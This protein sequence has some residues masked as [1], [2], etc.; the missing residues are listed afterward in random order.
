MPSSDFFNGLYIVPILA[1]LILIHEIGHFVSARMCG[2][3]VEEFGIGIPP[4]LFGVMRKGVLWSVNAIPFGGFVRVKGEDGKNVE[5]DSMN[6]KRPSQR[7]FFLAAGAGMNILLAIALMILV[8]GIEGIPHQSIYIDGV[9]S[10]SP[11]AKAG[12]QRGDRIVAVNGK[13]L[14]TADEVRT[15]A[16]ANAGREMT[17]TIERRGKLIDTTVS[18]RKNPPEGEGR[19]GVLITERSVGNL[20]IVE[21]VPDSPAAIAGLQVGDKIASINNRPVTDN[22]VLAT[23]L[24]R[25]IGSSVPL[26][27]ERNGQQVTTTIGVPTRRANEELT[28]TAGFATLKLVPIFEHVPALKVVPRGFEEA[29][30]TTKMMTIGLKELFS[31]RQ[32]LEQIAGPVGMGQLTSELVDESELPLWVTLANIAIVLSLNLALLNLLPIPALDGARLMFVLIE[33]LRGGRKIAP[34]KEGLVHLAGMVVLIGLMFVIA[35][36]DVRRIVSGESFL[37]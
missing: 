4:R 3:K 24:E 29:Y 16:A 21:L 17:T 12:W 5:P 35:F 9:S 14:E 18:P 2:V 30:N 36:S 26:V 33:V 11:A 32:N 23:E 22:Y 34:E 13:E 8:I 37:P 19:V 1:V 20:S 27:V 15:S 7:A 10:G 25:F 31:S 6:A 28:L